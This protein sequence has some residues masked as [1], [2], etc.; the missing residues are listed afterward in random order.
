MDVLT[1]L[2]AA[3]EA[4]Y[5]VIAGQFFVQA[6]NKVFSRN[7][8]ALT[9]MFL[10]FILCSVTRLAMHTDYI[11]ARVDM[12]LNVVLFVATWV[13]IISNQPGVVASSLHVVET[14]DNGR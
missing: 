12:V 4:S 14:K 9:S 2:H 5:F 11:S 3:V 7:G 1:F 8:L 13:F 6:R 10:I